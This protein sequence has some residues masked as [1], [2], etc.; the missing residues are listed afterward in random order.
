MLGER[1]WCR[2]S[3]SPSWLPRMSG[4]SPGQS[5][6]LAITRGSV[7]ASRWPTSRG[8]MMV[9]PVPTRERHCAS[10][11]VCRFIS[12]I[13]WNRRFG[14]SRVERAG[15]WRSDEIHVRSGAVWM[16]G[17]A[18]RYIARASCA[19]APVPASV[20]AGS[21]STRSV[22][23]RSRRAAASGGS[24]SGPITLT[25]AG[26]KCWARGAPERSVFAVSRSPELM[27]R[28][29]QTGR[30]TRALRQD[31]GVEVGEVD[32]PPRS[33]R[34]ALRARR[35]VASAGSPEVDGTSGRVPRE[36]VY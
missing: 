8:Q 18:I 7:R 1:A 31:R 13:V 32:S 4:R 9:S 36:S 22:S 3:V 28:A 2:P 24:D 10:S 21:A 12:S 30:K 27:R 26:R 11:G 33:P 16:I 25:S 14:T 34:D 5:R 15:T 29:A 17:I 20:W 6:T 23:E 35:P 19:S